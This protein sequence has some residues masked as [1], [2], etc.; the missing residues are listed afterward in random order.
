MNR[1]GNLLRT[2]RGS[3]S[4]VQFARHLELSYTFVRAMEHGQRFPSD[5]VLKKIAGIL[6]LDPAQLLLAAY[7]D[8]SENLA[9]VLTARG[10]ALPAGN[11]APAERAST[12]RDAQPTTANA[13]PAAPQPG[14][15]GQPAQATWQSTGT[16][17][18]F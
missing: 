16:S 7:C 12:P 5:P 18:P 8:R 6:H 13:S 2:A 17:R 3:E 10:L 1:L 15:P 9:E 14:Q 11:P 4:R